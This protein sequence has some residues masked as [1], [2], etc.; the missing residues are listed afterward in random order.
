MRPLSTILMLVA[1]AL[2]VSA[3]PSNGK[4]VAL[5]S[6][7]LIVADGTT[8]LE[9]PSKTLI[10]A[11]GTTIVQLPT[12]TYEREAA[13]TGGAAGMNAAP[14]LGALVGAGAM[15]VGLL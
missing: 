4:T 9:F 12:T 11:K 2:S 13:A 10:K 14:A 1:A 5:P 15:A 6:E 7:T 8:K 3:S